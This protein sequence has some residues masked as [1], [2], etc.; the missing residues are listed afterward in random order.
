M[1]VAL[2]P[3]ESV[4][5]QTTGLSS[6]SFLWLLGRRLICS[7]NHQGRSSLTSA[8]AI[9]M[10]VLCQSNTQALSTGKDVLLSQS[11][12]ATRVKTSFFEGRLSNGENSN[13]SKEGGH[14]HTLL[15]NGEQ[16]HTNKQRADTSHSSPKACWSCKPKALSKSDTRAYITR[17]STQKGQPQTHTHTRE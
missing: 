5:S 1:W 9:F 4:S 6:S 12:I 10:C 16:P 17:I 13:Q 11:A 2:I 8:S 3:T 14:R 15:I 7:T